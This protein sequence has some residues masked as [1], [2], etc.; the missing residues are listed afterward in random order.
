MG[1]DR[2]MRRCGGKMLNDRKKVYFSPEVNRRVVEEL[3]ELHRMN[4]TWRNFR[5]LDD[6]FS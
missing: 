5:N 3:K 4:L 2:R 6:N 1:K